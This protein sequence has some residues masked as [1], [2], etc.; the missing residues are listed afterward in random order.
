MRRKLA[1]VAVSF[2]PYTLLLIFSNVLCIPKLHP[3][4]EVSFFAMFIGVPMAFAFVTFAGMYVLT[5]PKWGGAE[6]ALAVA[7]DHLLIL[8]CQYVALGCNI[9]ITFLCVI[10]MFGMVFF[11]AIAL[12]MGL[13]FFITGKIGLT[14]VSRA[15]EEELLDQAY[16]Y[17]FINRI[18]GLFARYSCAPKLVRVLEA[19]TSN[20]S[21]EVTL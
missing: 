3:V 10:T 20:Q 4:T 9:C 14:A 17:W 19:K 12:V 13:N 21:Q 2:F 1:L 5:H 6:S 15:R 11:P 18:D 7:K 16:A 8:R